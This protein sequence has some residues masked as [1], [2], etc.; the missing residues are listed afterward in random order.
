VKQITASLPFEWPSRAKLLST[1]ETLA[2]GAAGGL[3]F[4]AAGLPGGLI[5]GSMIAVGIAAIAGRQLAV[6]PLLTQAV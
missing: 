1:A 2:I 5:S 6:P 4:V 3:A